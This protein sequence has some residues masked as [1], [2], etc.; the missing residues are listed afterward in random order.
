MAA[1]YAVLPELEEVADPATSVAARD[2]ANQLA[3]AL[4]AALSL[5]RAD[6]VDITDTDGRVLVSSDPLRLGARADLAGSD[7]QQGRG[8]S[9]LREVDGR[10]VVTAHA[11][12]SPALR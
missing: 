2:T 6:E 11:A 1:L 3:P 7:V 9:G 12:W 8:W 4:E 5:S 10:T